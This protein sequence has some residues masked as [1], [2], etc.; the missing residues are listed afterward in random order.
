MRM[1]L[2]GVLA[3]MREFDRGGAKKPIIIII[4]ILMTRGAGVACKS[5]KYEL[6]SLKTECTNLAKEFTA[7]V[8]L[9][10]NK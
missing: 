2:V 7:A 6:C 5:R 4:I 10:V 1:R 9:D 8:L 3:I